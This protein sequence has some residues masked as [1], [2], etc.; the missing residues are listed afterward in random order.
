MEWT[1]NDDG[2]VNLANMPDIDPF[3]ITSSFDK[4]QYVIELLSNNECM[5]YLG[6][7][8]DIPDDCFPIEEQ[9]LKLSFTIKI[10]HKLQKYITPIPKTWKEYH[11]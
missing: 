1:F 7:Q 2:R 11:Q 10:S 5:K 3:T 9:N 4:S 8:S 6:I